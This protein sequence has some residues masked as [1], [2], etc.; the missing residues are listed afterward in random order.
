MY[1]LIPRVAGVEG[2]SYYAGDGFNRAHI[3]PDSMVKTLMDSKNAI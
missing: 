2:E 1:R 3:L